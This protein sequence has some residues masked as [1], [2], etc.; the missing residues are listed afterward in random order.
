MAPPRRGALCHFNRNLIG[1]I[2]I[3][4]RSKPHPQ[5]LLKNAA[6]CELPYRKLILVCWH[7]YHFHTPPAKFIVQ[8]TAIFFKVQ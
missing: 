3:N 2:S 1:D 4:R 7:I 5:P 6:T 8:P